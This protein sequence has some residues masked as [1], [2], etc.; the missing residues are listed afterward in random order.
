MVRYYVRYS[1]ADV[2]ECVQA[3]MTMT[4]TRAAGSRSQCYARDAQLLRACY[5]CEKRRDA[6]RVD[7]AAVG[8]V[9]GRR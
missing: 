7:G 1:C 9:R 6:A 3:M 2:N 5:G 8:A 4:T